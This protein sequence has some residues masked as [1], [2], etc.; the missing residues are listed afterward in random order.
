MRVVQSKPD[1]YT[2]LFSSNGIAPTPF[3]YKNLGYDIFTDL[4]PVSTIGILD[5]LFMPLDAK[6]RDKT[7]QEFIEHAK[8]GARCSA[9][10]ASATGCIL[11][12]RSSVRRPAS[13]CSTFPTR[14]PR[15][16]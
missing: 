1:G 4:T 11:P 5:G 3:V 2:L 14:E 10:P 7:L 6:S 9:R 15:K 13:R 8:K 12:P 16:S